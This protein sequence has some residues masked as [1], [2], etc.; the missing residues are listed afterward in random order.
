MIIYNTLEAT[1][2]LSITLKSDTVTTITI[3]INNEFPVIILRIK[4]IIYATAPD[5][6]I[7]RYL[8]TTQCVS[9]IYSIT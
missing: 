3:T 5:I 1:S 4:I 2:V 7:A 8:F 6:T 9:L